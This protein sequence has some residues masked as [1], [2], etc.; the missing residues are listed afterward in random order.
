MVHLV[1][2]VFENNITSILQNTKHLQ[3][4]VIKRS[5]ETTHIFTLALKLCSFPYIVKNEQLRS[6]TFRNKAIQPVRK[7]ISS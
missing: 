6:V 4:V 1:F 7:N 3:S 2:S 5:A